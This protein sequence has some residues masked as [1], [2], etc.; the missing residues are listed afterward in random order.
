MHL[1]WKDLAVAELVG[2][3]LAGG[4]GERFDPNGKRNKLLASLPDG[5]PVA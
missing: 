3:L 2:L 4:R 5:R 1:H